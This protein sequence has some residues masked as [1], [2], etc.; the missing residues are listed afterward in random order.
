MGDMTAGAL[1]L[2]IGE[3]E[4]LLARG[5]AAAIAA[6]RATD[7]DAAVEEL[8]AADATASDLMA[9]VSPSLFGGVRVV[10]VHAAQDAKKEL[11]NALLE[12]AAAPDPEV[13]LVVT[14]V[15]GAKWLV[16]PAANSSSATMPT[17]FCAS[18]APC[19]SARPPDISH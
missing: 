7:P 8:T 16:S 2:V 14:H 12:Y 6:A 1:R 19:P 4:L 3:E 10:V 15:G 17:D 11:A 18:L 5:V 13:V 9:A